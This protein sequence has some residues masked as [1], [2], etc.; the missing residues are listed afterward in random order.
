MTGALR[1]NVRTNARALCA[2]ATLGESF[3]SSGATA[4]PVVCLFAPAHSGQEP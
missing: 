2:L 3:E 1:L 4:G